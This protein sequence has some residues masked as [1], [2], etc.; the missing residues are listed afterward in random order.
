MSINDQI[1]AG[2]RRRIGHYDCGEGPAHEF[3]AVLT[4]FPDRRDRVFELF[5]A[6]LGGHRKTGLFPQ[7]ARLDIMERDLRRQSHWSRDHVVH[8]L[9]TFFL[10]V[11]LEHNFFRGRTRVRAA[12]RHG[13]L[14]GSPGSLLAGDPLSAER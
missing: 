14:T 4:D 10:G 13:T 12:E 6:V 2:I 9:L 1:D 3:L 8:A 5:Q 7:L 11:Y